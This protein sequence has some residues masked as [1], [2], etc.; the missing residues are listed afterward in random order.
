MIADLGEKMQT[1]KDE[2]AALKATKPPKDF[3]VSTIK[4][5]LES[6]KAAPDSKAI[7]LLIERIDTRYSEEQEKTI[8]DIQSTLKTVLGNPGCGGGI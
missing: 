7:H 4:A 8:F 1:L 3:T 6:L 5:W 2:I